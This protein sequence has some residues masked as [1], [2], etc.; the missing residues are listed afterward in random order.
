MHQQL[1]PN[2]ARELFSTSLRRF[3]FRRSR[4]LR[5]GVGLR[6]EPDSSLDICHRYPEDAHDYIQ[7]CVSLLSP[8]IAA[9]DLL[10]RGVRP[11]GLAHSVRDIILTANL[12]SLSLLS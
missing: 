10:T 12:K 3:L 9:A 1:S 11:V 4:R 7:R 5:E 6:L 8:Q 2:K